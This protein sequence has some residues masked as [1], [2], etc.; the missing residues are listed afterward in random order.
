MD[1]LIGLDSGGTKC[2]VLI[3]SFGD[4]G[5]I[6]ITDKQ[7]YVTADNPLPEHMFPQL[8]AE[9]SNVEIRA[10]YSEYSDRI[11]KIHINVIDSLV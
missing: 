4:K 3:G 9:I 10:P 1:N 2:A 5:D 7:V 8:M 6:N 11:K